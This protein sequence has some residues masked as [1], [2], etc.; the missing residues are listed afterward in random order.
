MNDTI[1]NEKTEYS[2]WLKSSVEAIF[3]DN[4]IILVDLKKYIIILFILQ[5]TG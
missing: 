2:E 5:K 1:N 4:Q 3:S